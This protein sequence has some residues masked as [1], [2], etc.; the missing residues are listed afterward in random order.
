MSSYVYKK[1]IRYKLSKKEAGDY[2]EN[3]F[4]EDD[5]VE[6]LKLK[7]NFEFDLAWDFKADEQVVFLDKVY[8]KQY[9]EISGDFGKSRALTCKEIVCHLED[10]WKY[11]D[12][13]IPGD[14]RA[15]EYCYYN[16][17]DEPAYFDI[18]EEEEEGWIF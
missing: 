15:V 2:L 18:I 17:C 6:S 1:A 4:L 7:D 3:H 9:D 12:K 13:I 10:F 5:Y 11:N 14:L 8:E 16:G